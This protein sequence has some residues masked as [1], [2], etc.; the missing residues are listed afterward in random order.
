MLRQWCTTLLKCLKSNI[1]FKT[2]KSAHPEFDKFCN[3]NII[4]HLREMFTLPDGIKDWLIAEIIYS[5]GPPIQQT[6]VHTDKHTRDTHTHS[7]L[8]I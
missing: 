1:S 2:Y 8:H 4:L 3:F 5:E 7:F 6:Q